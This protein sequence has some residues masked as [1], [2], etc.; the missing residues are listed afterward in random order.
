MV[1]NKF[2]TAG[3]VLAMELNLLV[4]WTLW[5]GWQAW[6]W[7]WFWE[8]G[9]LVVVP[10]ANFVYWDWGLLSSLGLW[11]CLGPGG[12]RSLLNSGTGYIVNC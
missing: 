11:P 1:M 5:A 7:L 8:S 4:E 6:H 2:A 10:L 3:T 9:L 12:I